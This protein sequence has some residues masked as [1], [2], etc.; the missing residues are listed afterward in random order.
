[1]DP[2]DASPELRKPDEWAPEFDRVVL[3]DDGW[4]NGV[5]GYPGPKSWDEP[6]SREEYL[7]RLA[8]STTAP[9]N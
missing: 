9:R 3:D 5:D 6:I 8:N 7:Q 2:R 1:M 4:R